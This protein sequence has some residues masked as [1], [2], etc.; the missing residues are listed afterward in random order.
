MDIPSLQINPP[1]VAVC[2][3]INIYGVALK[4]YQT[5]FLVTSGEARNF[6]EGCRN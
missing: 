2:G 3:N 4:M 5:S 6:Q 1:M